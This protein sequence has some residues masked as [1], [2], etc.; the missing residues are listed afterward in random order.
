MEKWVFGVDVSFFGCT[1]VGCRTDLISVDQDRCFIVPDRHDATRQRTL[2]AAAWVAADQ[3]G[4]PAGAL[5][6]DLA[7]PLIDRTE[8]IDGQ[9]VRGGHA[10]DPS[11]SGEDWKPIDFVL[12]KLRLDLEATGLVSRQAPSLEVQVAISA[13]AAWAR[14]ELE[15][16]AK[17]TGLGRYVIVDHATA[18]KWVLDPE[19]GSADPNLVYVGLDY[20]G[21]SYTRAKA[22]WKTFAEIDETR[23]FGDAASLLR[24]WASSHGEAEHPWSLWLAQSHTGSLMQLLK[25]KAFEQNLAPLVLDERPV[26]VF[27]DFATDKLPLWDKAAQEGGPRHSVSYLTGVDL[28]IGAIRASLPGRGLLARDP[29]PDEN[30]LDVPINEGRKVAEAVIS[31]GNNA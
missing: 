26:C 1:V 29:A 20:C 3:S 13:P 23:L 25:P 11:S 15:G 19:S 8:E 16:A 14:F 12:R 4:V 24:S 2:P 28:A 17:R 31:R 5:V 9:V 7:L 30:L 10:F 18:A 22:D 6:G 21:Y 27:G